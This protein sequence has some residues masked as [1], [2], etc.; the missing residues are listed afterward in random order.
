[1]K[2]DTVSGWPAYNMQS[3]QKG[4]Q[5]NSEITFLLSD[6]QRQTQNDNE[7]V[8][9]VCFNTAPGLQKSYLLC[10]PVSH[11][12]QCACVSNKF[13]SSL[14]FVCFPKTKLKLN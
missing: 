11:S 6:M 8:I 13:I 4:S 10:V 9:C 14:H 7:N 1:M 2:L 12:V 5:F 3:I